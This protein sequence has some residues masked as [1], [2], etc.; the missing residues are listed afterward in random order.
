MSE[1]EL[2]PTVP[3]GAAAGMQFPADT[4]GLSGA[5]ACGM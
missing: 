1:H 4:R 5:C 2:R 3:A